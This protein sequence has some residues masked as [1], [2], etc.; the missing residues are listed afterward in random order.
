MF[1]CL[2]NNITLEIMYYVYAKG[3][4]ANNKTKINVTSNRNTN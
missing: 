3:R 2:L 4:K 1:W